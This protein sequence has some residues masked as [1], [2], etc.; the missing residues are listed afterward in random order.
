[1]HKIFTLIIITVF[2]STFLFAQETSD[3][4]TLTAKV[5]RTK[6]N[7]AVTEDVVTEGNFYFK[8]PDKMC[9]CFSEKK[10][11]LI[12]DGNAFTMI[13][14]GEKSVAKGKGAVHLG[15]LQRVMISIL[16]G[17]NGDIDTGELEDMEI[18]RQEDTIHI[19]PV[20]DSQKAK[21]R[22]IFTSFTLTIDQKI[23]RLK[24]MCM[25]EKEGNYTRYDFS[26]YMITNSQS[27]K[28]NNE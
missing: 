18:T 19:T 27:K 23:S 10:D 25:H 6:H 13:S 20:Y 21:R 5:V 16:R 2:S 11:M 8:E 3:T 12:M 4:H 17:E 22:M 1:M 14:N 15:L 26:D 9:I 7:T 28:K 24:S